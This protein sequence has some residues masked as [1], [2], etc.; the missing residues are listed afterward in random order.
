MNRTMLSTL[1]V[2]GAL[3][4]LLFG[5]VGAAQAQR[6]VVRG[7]VT[8]VDG[9]PVEG[10]SVFIVELAMQTVTDNTGKY[11]FTIPPA[12]VHGQ[13][14]HLRARMIGFRPGEQTLT[15]AAGDQVFDFKLAADVNRLEEIV[16]TGEMAGQSK[17]E[18]PFDITRV[19][20]ADLPVPALDPLSMLAG[21]V[22]GANIVSYSGRPGDSPTIL[23]RGVTSINGQDRSQ[24]PLYIVD[25]VI[26][27]S[28][29]LQ[30]LNPEDIASVEVVKGA[31]ASSLYGARAGS[32]AIQITTKSGTLGREGLTWNFHTEVGSS[33]IEKNWVLAQNTA[34]MTNGPTVGNA[35]NTRYCVLVTGAPLCAQTINYQAE[36]AV[37]N[38]FPGDWALVPP[39]F[40][41]DPRLSLT[42]SPLRN[43]FQANPWPGSTY[44]AVNDV[45]KPQLTTTTNLDAT[46]RFGQTQFYASGSFAQ[47]GGAIRYLSGYDRW[48]ARLNVDQRIGNMWSVGIRTFFS[49][50]R[51]DGQGQSNSSA[52]FDLTRVPA[53]VNILQTDTLGRLYVRTNLQNSGEQNVNPLVILQDFRSNQYTDR[54]IGGMD[55]RFTPTSWADVEGN[56]SYD[57][58]DTRDTYF[59]DKDFRYTSYNYW[60]GDYL[61]GGVT[62]NRSEA[63]SFNA[64]LSAT[65]RHD[66]GRDLQSRL[67]L[68]YSYV[69]QDNDNNGA[70]GY[71]LAA[72]GV[73]VLNN[74]TTDFSVGSG[75]SSVREIGY[76]AGVGLTYKDKYIAEALIRR[77]GSSLFGADRRWH[78]FGRGSL[79]WRV[80]Q[81]SF[82]PLKDFMNELKL[83]ASQGSAG[84][85]PNF[86][87]Q[88]QTFGVSAG[89]ISFGQSGN[90]LLEPEVTS[91]TELGADI[92]ILHRIGITITHAASQTQNQILPVSVPAWSGF[93]SVWKNAGTLQNKTWELSLNL[94][95]VTRH[96]LSWSWRF[97]WDAT[98]TEITALAVP[99]FAYGYDYANS[100]DYLF[101]AHV[102]EPYATFYGNY[103]LRSCSELPSAYQSQ[104]GGTGKA[105]QLN[106][107]GFLVWTGGLSPSQGITANAWQARLPGGQ[108]P[109]GVALNWGML[110]TAR[111]PACVA[112]PS[113]SCA[114]INLPLG[115][116]L[117]KWNG[118][119]GTNF[120]WKRLGLFALLQG[121]YGRKVWNEGRQWSYY[122]FLV[123]DVDQADRTVASAKP[124][125]Y[126]GRGA[127]PVNANG[128]GGFYNKLAPNSYFVEDASYAKLRELSLSYNFGPIGG[129]GNWTASL[130]G[131]NVFTITGYHGF[132]PETGL[133][134]SDTG[135][136]AI[137]AVDDYGFPNLRTLTFAI[138]TSF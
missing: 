68:R 63:R 95:V 121:S 12:R 122:D 29:A 131:R 135:S 33:G 32:G 50:G 70:S 100:G 52:F 87:A 2:A 75:T 27:G 116:A 80:A 5:T 66:F 105:Y 54:F 99:P 83:R 34:M 134:G 103:F 8:S 17:A 14:V 47:E 67:N 127:P 57:L 118:S 3:A 109:W 21:Q 93:S 98:K 106:D 1:R 45:V 138:T 26:L 90:A 74:A 113:T 136:G 38:N 97:S 129:W 7:T 44:N 94:P 31:A 11:L 23:L 86:Y 15:L 53:N 78:T 133:V 126:Y 112:A 60:S 84:G 79:A 41:L 125:G 9:T 39:P 22:P 42:A 76:S 10:G 119:V 110:I 107:Q 85:R 58:L 40:P 62:D 16:V 102:G 92:E 43:T 96:D 123:N 24:E 132:D 61:P 91:E 128:L 65:L 72:V 30:T 104:C 120:Q 6:A 111:D 64:G 117:P 37:I 115:T 28:G 55:V 46:G 124:L 71:T 73:P 69:Q 108:A 4:A 20:V 13:T 59:Y 19:D 18:T 137:N 114:G 51:S 81:E 49:Q 130:V 89:G 56:L 36:Q 101:T 88:Y 48:T 25:G 77:D 35:P 82:W